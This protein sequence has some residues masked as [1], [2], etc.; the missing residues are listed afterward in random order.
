V[1]INQH[2][3]KK[4][5]FANLVADE[6]M[7][8][9]MLKALVL[10]FE[11]SKIEFVGSAV[12]GKEEIY[13]DGVLVSEKRNLTSNRSVHEF[14]LPGHGEVVLRTKM[15]LTDKKMDYQLTA[16]AAVLAEGQYEYELRLASSEEAIADAATEVPRP[17]TGWLSLGGLGLKLFKS[18]GVIKAALFGA[19]YASFAVLTDW[20][21]GALLI[22]ILVF[23]EYGH[24]RAM[25]SFGM[26][27]KGMY[28]IPFVGG[29]AIGEKA[30][31]YWQETYISMQGPVFGLYMTLL[32]W[33][34]YALTGWSLLGAL[35]TFSALIN[36][37]NLL[38]IYPL[39]GGHVVKA[40]ALS[41]TNN[42][43]WLFPILFAGFGVGVSI[44]SGLYLLAFFS[45]LGAVDLLGAQ[46]TARDQ[47]V[48]PMD[49]Y[50]VLVSLA[51]YVGTIAVFVFVMY[52]LY[53]AEVPGGDI[54][55][56]ILRDR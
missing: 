53:L 47:D 24:L 44:W 15:H 48:T 49:L 4:E 46:R 52:Q 54:P 39:D 21:L 9:T 55:M 43:S 51:W 3:P 40:C 6:L 28:L 27:T 19:S 45:V 17:Q 38:P 41:M 56:L 1:L 14:Q 29:V 11:G 32:A 35:A 23:H 10:S 2:R 16:G 30:T 7:S 36:V 8:K 26:Q 12:S 13:V 22:A 31:T 20:R 37:F 42:R 18:A 33:L 34:A 50:G 5:K 25:R